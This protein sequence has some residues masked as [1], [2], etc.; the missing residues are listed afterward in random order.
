M[1]LYGNEILDNYICPLIKDNKIIFKTSGTTGEPKEISHDLRHFL[2]RYETERPGYKTLITLDLTRLGGIDALF[3]VYFYGGTAII[4]ETKYPLEALYLIEN[5]KVE[6]LIASPSF[7]KFL[8]LEDVEKYDMSS[9]KIISYGSEKISD[10]LLYSISLAFPNVKLKQTYGLTEIGTLRTH[11]NGNAIQILDREWKVEDDILYIKNRGEWICTGDRVQQIGDYI[12]ILG[13]DSNVINVGGKKVQAEEVESVLEDI[14]KEALVY[15][16][17]NEMIG[18]IIVAN[19]ITNMWT[20]SGIISYCKT[21]LAKYK[22]PMKINFVE[23]IEHNSNGK[24][25]RK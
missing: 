4:P 23:N 13:R 11:S 8:L 20:E 25:V 3:H 19:V 16:E 5:Y 22:V 21:R 9:L 17:P 18:N 24:K 14:C 6:L 10:S 7:L 15:G 12:K 1:I 2:K